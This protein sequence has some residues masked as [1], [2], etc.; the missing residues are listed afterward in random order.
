[1][2]ISKLLYSVIAIAFISSIGIAQAQ[3]PPNSKPP[4]P[5][6]QPASPTSTAIKVTDLQ[7]MKRAIGKFWQTDR[8]ET[9]SQIEIDS[10]D[11]KGKNKYF[12]S[13]KTIARIGRKFH[14]ELTIDRV[15]QKSKVKYTI[16][17]DGK[18]VWVYRPDTR[19]Y[20]KIDN[21]ELYGK[22]STAIIGLFSVT[23]SALKTRANC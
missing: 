22:P 3:L 19:Q 5:Q 8:S 10:S 15:G 21:G 9:E 11:K 2:N 20:T 16:F 4:T 13:V 1:M 6:S 7:L 23:F 14:S 12:V 17:S 18:T